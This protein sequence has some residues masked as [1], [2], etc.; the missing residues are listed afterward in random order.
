MLVSLKNVML[1]TIQ[2]Q[3]S[4]HVSYNKLIIL[5]LCYL[6]YNYNAG[7][8]Y[9]QNNYNVCVLLLTKQYKCLGR[10]THITFT[11][12]V[13]CYLQYNYNV[14]VMLLTLYLLCF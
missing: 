3:C 1:L 4:G 8:C 7:S 12:C 10:V 11:M 14:C 9:L 2:L 6:Q 5:V 13:S